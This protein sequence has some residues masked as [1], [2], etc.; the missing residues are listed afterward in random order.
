MLLAVPLD[1]TCPIRG[2]SDELGE[3]E[4]YRLQVATR[5]ADLVRF[6]GLAEGKARRF[7]YFRPR[8]LR[9]WQ[10]VIRGDSE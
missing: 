7:V 2:K 3:T 10:G 6:Q 5:L 4:V 1:R 9:N 8:R